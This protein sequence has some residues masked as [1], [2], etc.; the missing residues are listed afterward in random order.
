MWKCPK[1]VLWIHNCHT[2]LYAK[3]LSFAWAL[4]CLTRF[5]CKHQKAHRGPDHGLTTK[6]F[7]LSVYPYVT[8]SADQFCLLSQNLSKI[9]FDICLGMLYNCAHFHSGVKAAFVSCTKKA[10]NWLKIINLVAHAAIS[11][12]LVY[13]VS[14]HFQ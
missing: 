13:I 10:K 2:L 12:N 5:I 8:C 7:Q 1:V 9:D 14:G 11:S 4:L 3:M 6:F